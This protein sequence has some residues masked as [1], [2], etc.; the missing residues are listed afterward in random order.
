MSKLDLSCEEVDAN[1]SPLQ[2]MS[3]FL[4]EQSPT[5]YGHSRPEHSTIR[6]FFRLAMECSALETGKREDLAR[7]VDV[8]CTNNEKLW[9]KVNTSLANA[10][11][12]CKAK[13][14]AS[15]VLE[16]NCSVKRKYSE[17]EDS[18]SSFES[19]PSCSYKKA[20]AEDPGKRDDMGFITSFRKN[21]IGRMN[22]KRCLELA[23]EKKTFAN[24]FR[25]L[26]VFD[27]SI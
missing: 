18:D 23:H 15:R 13:N 9:H 16:F 20:I 4:T 27:P 5:L 14:V 17:V 12:T 26:K 24:V 7:V 1:V 6:M 19:L 10:P 11:G 2:A 21:Q 22:W 8:I 3:M 25:Q